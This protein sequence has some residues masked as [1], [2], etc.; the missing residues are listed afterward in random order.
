MHTHRMLLR[1]LKS[2]PDDLLS[3]SKANESALHVNATQ[4]LVQRC[5]PAYRVPQ[6][7]FDGVPPDR[8]HMLQASELGPEPSAHIFAL[9]YSQCY[10]NSSLLFPTNAMDTLWFVALAGNRSTRRFT[11]TGATFDILCLA[12]T[13]SWITLLIWYIKPTVVGWTVESWQDLITTGTPV[14]LLILLGPAVFVY[15][16]PVF[17][18][19]RV[20]FGTSL[21][22]RRVTKLLGPIQEP[23]SDEAEDPET[24]RRK[25]SPDLE[26][27]PTTT[28]AGSSSHH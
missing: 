16:V 17:A 18:P 12:F 25:P 28:D 5:P 24:Q 21:F 27:P 23:D 10:Y 14:M 1:L 19:G 7:F 22:G 8:S 3:H 26:A 4:T 15:S 9:D 6:G 20:N 2:P 13:L 11:Q